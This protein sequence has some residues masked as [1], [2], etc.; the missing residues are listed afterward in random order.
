MDD[1]AFT[2]WEHQTNAV[3]RLREAR[4]RGKTRIMLQLPPGGGKTEIAVDVI[5]SARGKGRAVAFTVPFLTLVD[6]T[7]ARFEKRGLPAE[8]IGVMQAKHE[9]TNEIAKIQV[10]SVS[11][12]KNRAFPLADVVF[13][14]EAHIQHA[15]IRKWIEA[16]P[17]ITFVGLS[18]TPW[19]KGLADYWDE[20]VIVETIQGLIDK[21]ILCPF[22]TFA[23]PERADVSRVA[24][25]SKTQDYA[26]GELSDVMQ[27]DRLVADVVKTWLEKAGGRPTFCFCV[28]RA[29]AAKVTNQFLSIGVKAA[30]V[31]AFVEQDERAEYI[32]QLRTGEVQIVVSIGTLTTGVDVP[33]VS[34]IS[35][36]R[37]TRSEML[38]VQALCRGLRADVER[39][40]TDCI[41]LDHSMTTLRMGLVSNVGFS[42][43]RS[44][45][46]KKA[47]AVSRETPV[48]LPRECGECHFMIPATMRRCP[49]CGFVAQAQS[50]IE[51]EDGELVEVGV[52]VKE[53]A[54]RK[55]N[56]DWTWAEKER[57][58]GGLKW[59]ADNKG[60]QPGWAANKY[61]ARFG[62]WP[63]DPRVK[64]AHAFK[65]DNETMAWIYVE[66]KNY[67]RTQI[68]KRA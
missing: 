66:Q 43:L 13:V 44:G 1:A 28:D 24:I 10:I 56:Q 3:E 11:T 59:Y 52:S 48:K 9:R 6:Q 27:E 65:P 68:R 67:I 34:C 23:P 31:D 19:S 22:K 36:V 21:G 62:V 30:Y 54:Q 50:E 2:P 17:D 32:E 55:M 8:D 26:T 63:N 53:R 46:K 4:R 25:N 37:P 20:L 33:W 60:Y 7:V 64:Y 51:P 14:D 12:L 45:K 49:E 58:F 61:K 16:C 47:E 57:F 38:F 15:A 5:K 42:E 18:A 29:H 41:I 35:F 40:K 39:G